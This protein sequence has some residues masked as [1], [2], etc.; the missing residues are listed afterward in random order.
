MTRAMPAAG[1][2]QPLK[3][4]LPI[5]VVIIGGSIAGLSCAYTLTQAGHNVSVF[6]AADDLGGVRPSPVR[7][8]NQLTQKQSPGG[9]RVPPNMS[10]IL[11]RWGL[12]P[13][14]VEQTSGR[15][16]KPVFHSGERPW[17]QDPKGYD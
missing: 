13:A 8:C 6:E 1:F 9:I 11:F 10:R 12:G 3:A 14:I 7:S 17:C 4:E 15:C 2:E 16:P 5:N